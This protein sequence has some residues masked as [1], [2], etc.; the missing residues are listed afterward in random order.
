MSTFAPGSRQLVRAASQ[1]PV[2]ED[3]NRMGCP[4]AVLN[5]GLRPSRQARVRAGKSGDLWSS[6]ATDMA[7][8]TR[9][10]TLV[11][12]GTNRKFRPATVIS[13]DC[14]P[15][16]RDLAPPGAHRRNLITRYPYPV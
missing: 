10:G 14:A 16:M 11:G 5:T 7:R 9:S 6:E 12:P 13:C 3:G 2:P 8:N 4:V 15:I 1:H